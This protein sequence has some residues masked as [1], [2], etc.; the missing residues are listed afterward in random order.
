MAYIF[1]TCLN[2]A[3]ENQVFKIRGLFL[4]SILRQNIGWYDTTCNGAASGDFASRMTDDLNKLQEGIGEKIGLFIFF[5][6]I[7]T[8][9]LINAFVHGWQLTLV[10]LAAMPILMIA[11]GIIAKS[12]TALTEKEL[13]AYSKAGSIAEQ[14][15]RSIKTVVAFQGQ[16]KEVKR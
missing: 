9:S 14:A 7:F 16:S 1:V 10:I 12:Q 13:E 3:A 5:M 15:M 8:A 11:V 6:T 2:T 4:K